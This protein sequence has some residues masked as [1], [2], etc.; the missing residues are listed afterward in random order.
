MTHEILTLL[1]TAQR[2][3]AQGK[4]LVL[5]T[6]VSLEGSSYRRPGVRMLI[7][8]SNEMCGA[9]SGGCVE[10][11]VLYKAQSV[12]SK[13]I[14]K[15][16]SYDGRYRLGCEGI[17]YLLIEPFHV[18][19]SLAILLE[20]INSRISFNC[21]SYYSLSEG[22]DTS[23]GSQFIID[24]VMIPVQKNYQPSEE[25]QLCFE[26]EFPPLFQLYIFG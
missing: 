16:M 8:D 13:G 2:W 14:P 23:L 3:H 20:S 4:R 25:I 24:S 18:S 26:Q 15:I 7:A 11:E 9:V 22:E 21:V 17:L 6:V 5:A 10:K 1:E 12:F 19:E